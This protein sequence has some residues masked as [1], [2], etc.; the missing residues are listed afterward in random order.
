MNS[1]ITVWLDVDYVVLRIA[2]SAHIM[3]SYKVGLDI[4]K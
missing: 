4:G 3:V 2:E 1:S